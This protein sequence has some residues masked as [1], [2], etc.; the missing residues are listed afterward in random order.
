VIV[1]R[2]SVTLPDGERVHA[3]DLVTQEP[4][5][6]GFFRSEFEYAAAWL[7][8]PRRFALVPG[9]DLDRALPLDVV[10]HRAR[11]FEPPLAL[12]DDA[13]PDSWGRALLI[14][15]LRKRE[16]SLPHSRLSPPHLL[17]ELGAGGLGALAFSTEEAAA[18]VPA[19]VGAADLAALMRAAE[20]FESGREIEDQA[21]RRLLAAGSSAGGARP[22]ALV[23]DADGSWIAKFKSARD[24]RFDVVGLEAAAMQAAPEAGLEAAETRLVALGK[25]KVL[26]V[27]RFDVTARGRRHMLSLRTLL[28]AR[29][30]AEPNAYRELAEAIRLVGATPSADV[31]RLFR[32]MAYNA[33]IGNTDDHAKNFW[34]LHG[35]DGWH[36]SPAFDLVP[37]YQR[38]YEHQ[39]AFEYERYCPAGNTLLSIARAW[40]IEAMLDVPRLLREVVKAARGLPGAAAKLGVAKTQVAAIEKD[41]R[42]RCERLLAAL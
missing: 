36:P 16:P 12:F 9:P 15:R 35:D 28:G 29:P 6:H 26:L 7:G 4:D 10:R 8:H 30:G 21:L 1:V 40:G 19:V 14:E 37:D 27:K 32:Q 11:G 24:E 13:L 25:R 34:M 18:A 39:L 3:G 41:I 31:A 33:A 22:K 23:R 17:I 2:V 38:R 20:D 42:Q 5:A